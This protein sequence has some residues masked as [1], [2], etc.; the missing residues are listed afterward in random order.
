MRTA[1]SM[2]D[3]LE[4]MRSIYVAWL[5]TSDA[6]PA[7]AA[8][9]CGALQR[10]RD[11]ERRLRRLYDAAVRSRGLLLR[12]R[13]PSAARSTQRGHQA[14]WV[15]RKISSLTSQVGSWA[16]LR[17][18][19]AVFHGD[20][21]GGRGEQGGGRCTFGDRHEYVALV[22]HFGLS[23]ER[24]TEWFEE[25]RR[26]L[27][28]QARPPAD[29]EAAHHAIYAK[30]VRVLW[31]ATLLVGLSSPASGALEGLP[32]SVFA[33][34]TLYP[35][36]DDY[37]DGQLVVA[38][39]PEVAA[40]LAESPFGRFLA[41]AILADRVE[42]AVALAHPSEG[43]LV[44]AVAPLLASIKARMGAGE[45][46]WQVLSKDLLTALLAFELDKSPS[47]ALWSA[48]GKGGL[49]V[50]FLEML[51]SAPQA[52]GGAAL[53]V[54]RVRRA[55]E[56]GFLLQMVDDLQ[57][58]TEDGLRNCQTVALGASTASS[59]QMAL[60]V[61][62][63]AFAEAFSGAAHA[64]PSP[65]PFGRG[66]VLILGDMIKVLLCEAAS[67]SPAMSQDDIGALLQ[68]FSALPQPFL[69][70][71]SLE[72]ILLRCSTGHL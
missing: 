28:L 34:A 21:V 49:T 18:W 6:P 58:L 65:I 29:A 38:T 48:I 41:E 52:A 44:A 46:E 5:M 67:K 50:L 32:E 4:E 11:N 12:R 71:H 3:V 15:G 25:R 14:C 37:I 45:E 60:Y 30:G 23:V 47:D 61:R 20:A 62:T 35:L 55:I 59:R 57:D 51:I 1:V 39:T 72:S 56:L 19:A 33:W 8:G 17:T 54:A 36:V 68:R 10:Q 9:C 53:T 7:T 43:G 42:G 13:H 70:G 66:L 31:V 27:P 69:V 16:A 63:I 64:T 40:P 2:L 24:Y 22:R 26:A